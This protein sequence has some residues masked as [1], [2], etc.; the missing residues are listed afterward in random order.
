MFQHLRSH[1]ARLIIKKKFREP[2]IVIYDKLSNKLL[3]DIMYVDIMLIYVCCYVCNYVY[4]L[5]V[6]NQ[7]NKP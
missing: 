4:V 6:Y 1:V 3:I 2:I 5:Y 7:W